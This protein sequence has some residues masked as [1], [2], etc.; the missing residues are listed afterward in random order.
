MERF[1]KERRSRKKKKEYEE[2]KTYGDTYTKSLK[3][4]KRFTWNPYEKR[5]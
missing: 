2:M 4:F 5:L 3:L 1:I